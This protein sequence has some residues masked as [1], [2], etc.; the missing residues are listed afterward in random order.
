LYVIHLYAGIAAKKAENGEGL[1][2]PMKS[3][4]QPRTDQS[5][6][7]HPLTATAPNA[8]D[9]NNGKEMS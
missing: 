4:S 3:G 2:R 1:T 5:Q 9:D 7:T 6:A 8:S